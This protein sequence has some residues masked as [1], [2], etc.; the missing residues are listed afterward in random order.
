MGGH[1]AAPCAPPIR[2]TSADGS[3]DFLEESHFAYE[4]SSRLFTRTISYTFFQPAHLG[5]RTERAHL[6]LS[7]PEEM[8]E[9]L[10]RAG[11]VV[12]SLWGGYDRRPL[13]DESEAMI[14]SAQ[15]G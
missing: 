13:T 9:L 6:R 15:S 5:R 1:G 10:V 12:E 2:R 8:Q 11:L 3:V 7:P 4:A 14:F